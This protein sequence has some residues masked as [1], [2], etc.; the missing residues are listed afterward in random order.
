LDLIGF[1]KND[2]ESRLMQLKDTN[3]K[4]RRDIRI[5]DQSRCEVEVTLWGDTA[6]SINPKKDDIIVIK[7]A[8]INE[9][10]EK[11]QVNIGFTT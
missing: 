6:E 5:Y 3:S 9:Y 1:V 4:A 10:R 7:D 2:T 11:K 8:R